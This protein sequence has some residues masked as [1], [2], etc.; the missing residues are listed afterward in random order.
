[1]PIGPDASVM[2]DSVNPFVGEHSPM[3]I[4]SD[5]FGPTSGI[6]QSGV[7]LRIGR[8]Y[9]GRV[10]LCGDPTAHVTVRL[11]WPGGS[12]SV[13]I[14][15]LTAAYQAYPF[16]LDPGA[17]ADAAK[18][19]ISAAG[20]G[21]FHIGAVSLMPSDNISGFRHEVVDLL[22]SLHSGVYR[23]PGGNYISNYQW[24][25]TVGPIDKRPPTW[26]YAWNAIQPN[27][28]GIDE[29]MQ[30]WKLLDA[31]P[32]FTLNAGFGDANPRGASAH[33]SYP[34]NSDC[35]RAGERSRYF[36]EDA[37]AS[38]SVRSNA[39]RSGATRASCRNCFDRSCA[40]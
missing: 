30:L 1:M 9:T 37:C 16:T 27:D 35:Y 2:M 15:D 25:N 21:S 17:D 7:A 18:F 22:A 10:I 13:S 4:L 39:T 40:E 33:R 29:F 11:V 23:F 24:Q 14:P 8:T 6:Q 38:A 3:V 5:K 31:D 19:E 20:S 12:K 36:D 26:D 32:Y 28:V 34:G